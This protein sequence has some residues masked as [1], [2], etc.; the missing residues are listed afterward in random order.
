SVRPSFHV[1]EVYKSDV[2]V[3]RY[4]ELGRVKS[5]LPHGDHAEDDGRHYHVEGEYVDRRVARPADEHEGRSEE[6]EE[7]EEEEG[8]ADEARFDHD[9]EEV[10]VRL[11]EVA[12]ELEHA[13]LAVADD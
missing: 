10:V 1:Y 5:V 8:R 4:C 9:A 12:E 2:H 13:A 3:E 6:I 7:E 11:V